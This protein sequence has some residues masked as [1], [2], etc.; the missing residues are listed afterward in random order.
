MLLRINPITLINREPGYNP[1]P[2]PNHSPKQ[3]YEWKNLSRCL[4]KNT[5]VLQNLK[6]DIYP[7]LKIRFNQGEYKTSKY[8]RL[9]NLA[10]N[11]LG[12]I[13][14]TEANALNFL[15]SSIDIA[16][17]PNIMSYT[18]GKYQGGTPRYN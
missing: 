3:A 5:L 13:T 9:F 12:K 4:N 15:D 6:N 1:Q 8:L 17:N 16:K 11:E 18:N 14:K 10:I 2:K 7:R